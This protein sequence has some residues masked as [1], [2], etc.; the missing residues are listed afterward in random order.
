M[1]CHED[2]EGNRYDFAFG[3]NWKGRIQDNRT[4][5]YGKH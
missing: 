5:K 4:E 3:L 2:T 1:E